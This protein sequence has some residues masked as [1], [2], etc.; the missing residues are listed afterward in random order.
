LRFLAE[1]S[2]GIG[3]F[4]VPGSKALAL[5]MI[6]ALDRLSETVGTTRPGIH[7]ELLV[8]RTISASFPMDATPAK[9]AV[10]SMGV[11]NPERVEVPVGTAADTQPPQTP[12]VE[13]G[14][15]QTSPAPT[16]ASVEATGWST[17]FVL[18]DALTS[19]VAAL[20]AAAGFRNPDIGLHFEVVRSAGRLAASRCTR[21]CLSR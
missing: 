4:S 7:P 21:G 11:D 5:N 20:R 17:E 12:A 10:Y 19:A 2:A 14:A 15:Q 18:Q 9:V 13:S 8:K 3:P 6:K 16:V 1:L